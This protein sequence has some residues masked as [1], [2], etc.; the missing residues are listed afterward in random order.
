MFDIFCYLYVCVSAWI[1]SCV[2]RGTTEVSWTQQRLSSKPQNRENQGLMAGYPPL[3]PARPHLGVMP[4]PCPLS[5]ECQ[6]AMTKEEEKK[7]QAATFDVNLSPP[8]LLINPQSTES[9]QSQCSKE[10]KKDKITL[11]S[12]K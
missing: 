9:Y 2:P 4:C 8:K 6:N 12:F 11:F 1:K 10:R 5:A 7:E 3:N